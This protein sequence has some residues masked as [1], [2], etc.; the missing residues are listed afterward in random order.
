MRE[1]APRAAHFKVLAVM[2]VLMFLSA[3]SHAAIKVLHSFVPSPPGFGSTAKL[4]QDPA[5]N[6]YGTTQTDGLYGL[7]T[8]FKLEP[9]ANGKWQESVIHSFEGGDDDGSTPI[10][11]LVFDAAGNLYGTTAL[12]GTG[13]C[14]Y[15]N[16]CGTVFKLSPGQG[17]SWTESVLYD[18]QPPPDGSSPIGNLVIDSTGNLFGAAEYGGTG[19]GG[20]GGGVVFELT[21]NAEGKWTET[22]IHT[23]E[24]GSD[25]ALPLAGLIFDQQG[26]LY[27]TTSGET[28]IGAGTVFELTPKQ[29]DTWTH[30]VL[31]NFDAYNAATQSSLVFDSAGNLYGTGLGGPGVGCGG[32]GCGFVF[33][34]TAGSNGSWTYKTLYV[35]EGGPDGASPMAGVVFDQAG[36]LY[37]TTFTGGTPPSDCNLGSTYSGCGTVFQL[38]PRSNGKWKESII[39]R[40]AAGIVANGFDSSGVFPVAS[41]LLDQAGNLYGTTEVGGSPRY[42]AGTVFKLSPNRGSSWASSVLYDFG[43]HKDGAQPKSSVVADNAGNLYGTNTLG[44]TGGCFNNGCGTV[45]K[46]APSGNG[47]KESVIYNFTRGTDGF[48]SESSLVLDPAGNLYGTA[49]LGGMQC[50]DSTEECGTVFKL[51]PEAGGTW[52]E[53]TLHQFAGGGLDGA[54]PISGLTLDSEGN[55][56][57][58]TSQGGSCSG[59]RY[60]CGTV[61]EVKPEGNSWVE[62]ILYQFAGGSDGM[63][64]SIPLLLDSAGNLYGATD[65]TVFQ[66][67]PNSGGGWSEKVIYSVTGVSGLIFDDRDNLYGTASSGGNQK[68]DCGMV[69]ELTRGTKGVWT[70]TVLHQFSGYDGAYPAGITFDSAG[71]LYGTTTDGGENAEGLIFSLTPGT[72]GEWT[73]TVLNRFD[74]TNGMFP[75]GPPILDA[76]GNLF[77]T[78][79]AGGLDDR[80]NS[81]GSGVVFEYS[82]SYHEL[83]VDFQ[84]THQRLLKSNRQGGMTTTR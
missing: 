23:F 37:G 81:E 54:N 52:K 13:V 18:F 84:D 27:G 41:L 82:P 43:L 20:D 76:N 49:Y 32:Y 17:G 40:F 64:P 35:F 61:F 31:Y 71:V 19:E 75:N 38:S 7:G 46:I 48:F 83:K 53:T 45:Y 70:E 77:G 4:I 30:R 15:G 2:A 80:G 57:G 29:N 8:V 11:G 78:T 51:T 60:G 12:G 28:N 36:N 39:Y 1:E 68:C 42:W 58:T 74:G 3:T 63:S 26:N 50:S 73:E 69:F 21:P 6:L 62:S 79:S 55:V 56:Y 16:A 72:G 44:G 25:G 59:G 47:W 14:Q 65:S 67:T 24:G 5:G 66:L 9:R 33:E 34:L 10:G 22:I